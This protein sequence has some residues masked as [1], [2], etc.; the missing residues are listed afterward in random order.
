[1]SYHYKWRTQRIRIKDAL[2]TVNVRYLCPA[3]HA[4][5][6]RSRYYSPGFLRIMAHLRYARINTTT[7]NDITFHA[8]GSACE[9]EATPTV[10]TATLDLRAAHGRPWDWFPVVGDTPAV[11]G[12]D[13]ALHLVERAIRLALGDVNVWRRLCGLLQSLS[14]LVGALRRRTARWRAR[15]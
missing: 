7:I 13:V 3:N 15:Q 2:R 6:I 5:H 10:A 12:G 1:M 9:T 14:S 8:P 11:A 4:G